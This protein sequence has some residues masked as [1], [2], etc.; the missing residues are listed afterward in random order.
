MARHRIKTSHK[1]TRVTYQRII[2]VVFIAVG[3]ASFILPPLWSRLRN[4]RALPTQEDSEVSVSQG[5]SGSSEFGPIRIAEGLLSDKPATQPPTRIIIPRLVIDIPV[6]ESR[7]VGGY[8]EVS[9]TTA[10]HGIGSGNPGEI[11]NMVIFAHARAGLFLPLRD[12]REDDSIYVLTNDRWYRY[13]VSETKTVSPDQVE[14]IR[15]TSEA[16]LTLFTC[17]G[18]LDTKRLVVVAKPD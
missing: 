14:V 9:E 10:S 15:P 5:R 7:V 1:K 18:F 17:S 16:T 8:W 3:L 13:R 2:A 4:V 11:G 12:I 6:R